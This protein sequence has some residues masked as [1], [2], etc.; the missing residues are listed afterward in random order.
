[1]RTLI[2]FV[3]SATQSLHAVFGTDLP[4]VEFREGSEQAILT[5]MQNSPAHEV[6][7]LSLALYQ[8]GL[9]KH[10]TDDEFQF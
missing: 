5:S 3:H 1:M 2:A 8:M 9:R 4:V 10:M 7:N 6:S